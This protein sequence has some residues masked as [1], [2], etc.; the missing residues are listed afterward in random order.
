MK[1]RLG[2]IYI[3]DKYV[4]IEVLDDN[5]SLATYVVINSNNSSQLNFDIEKANDESSYTSNWLDNNEDIFLTEWER[6]QSDG[7][8][9]W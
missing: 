1:Q 9:A 7:R 2:T 3:T 5:R 8:Y 6:Q 4:E